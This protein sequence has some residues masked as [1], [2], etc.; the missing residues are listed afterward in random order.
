MAC[1]D[2]VDGAVSLTLSQ[3]MRSER[4]RVAIVTHYFWP[5]NSRVNDLVAELS[6]RGHHVQV[7]AGHPNYPDGK[8]LD[9]YGGLM[10]RRGTACGGSVLR[11]PGIPRKQGTNRQLLANY[12]S[13]ATSATLLGPLMLHGPL[14]AV[15]AF[16][17]SPMTVALPALA[18]ARLK[19]A[20]ALMWIQDL[21]P[22]TLDAMGILDR[23]L[24]HRCSLAGAAAVH[25]RMD[26][27]LVQSRAFSEPL[28]QQGV[29]RELIH[30]VPNWAEDLYQPV[31]VGDDAPERREMPGGFTIVFAGNIGVAQGLDTLLGAAELL[32]G[33]EDL[34]W[35]VLGSGRQSDWLAQQVKARDLHD[36]V[37]LLGRRPIETMPAWFALGDALLVTLQPDPVYAMTIPSKLQSYLACGRPV[38]ASLDGEGARVV[39]ESGAGFATPAGDAAALAATARRM[40]DIG[41]EERAK[42]G[43]RGRV[44]YQEN[45]DRTAVIDRIEALLCDAAGGHNRHRKGGRR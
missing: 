26:T 8:F 42:I 9:G 5:E 27:L 24:P 35:V 3:A 7:L 23:G 45:F 43:R 1:I 21:W 41:S 2:H 32:R 17:P 28:I 19:H 34:R 13:F 44:Y 40:Y 6:T 33:V 37:L 16:Q 38:L 4:L 20:P 25:R 11:V 14:D 10:P 29:R 30:Y 36:T 18:L 15:L 31:T 12:L 39:E 22:D